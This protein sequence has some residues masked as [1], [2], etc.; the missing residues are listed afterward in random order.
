MKNPPA[1]APVDERSMQRGSIEAGLVLIPTT[2]FFLA[3]LQLLLA[4][5]WQT[6]ERARLHDIVIESSIQEA[7]STDS[8]S[9]F[10]GNEMEL[11][12]RGGGSFEQSHD[13][14][15]GGSTSLDVQEKFTP[16]GTL[17]TFEMTTQLPIIGGFFQA[18]D[19]G[20]FQIKNYAVS[21]I[22]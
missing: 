12:N 13:R 7:I 1:I 21:I 22:S 16:I 18:L 20:F 15:L 11:N 4:G 19:G 6:I 3:A 17:R 9:T 8:P 2:L 14:S 10:R 5:S